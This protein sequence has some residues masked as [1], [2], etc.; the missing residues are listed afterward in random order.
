MLENNL[1]KNH[2][3][4]TCLLHD[5]HMTVDVSPEQGGYNDT[6]TQEVTQQCPQRRVEHLEEGEFQPV[7]IHQA[8]NCSKDQSSTIICSICTIWIIL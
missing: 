5:S 7:A 4:V 8:S 1:Y 3:T 6:G 2:V